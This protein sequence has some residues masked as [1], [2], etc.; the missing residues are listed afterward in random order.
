M[1]RVGRKVFDESTAVVRVIFNELGEVRHEGAYYVLQSG[2]R[3]PEELV[4]Q[5]FGS[6]VVIFKAGCVLAENTILDASNEECYMIKR[7][8]RGAVTSEVLIPCRAIHKIARLQESCP[9][10]DGT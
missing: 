6:G 8:D 3:V 9:C 1:N 5:A 4:E 2:F 10:K 7:G